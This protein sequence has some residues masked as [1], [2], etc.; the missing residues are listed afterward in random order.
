MS[1]IPGLYFVI[2]GDDLARFVRPDPDNGLHTIETMDFA[3]IHQRNG[4]TRS[5]E[6]DEPP[7][8]RFA[9]LLATLIDEDFAVDLFSHLVLVAPP[10]LLHTLTAT[11]DPSTRAS[12]YGSLAKNLVTVPDLELWPHFLTWL[13]PRQT[14]WAP[15]LPL[16][17]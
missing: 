17:D 13:Q 16:E 10:G 14:A 9:H 6:P 1:G 12:L 11:L 15:A 7:H 5:P 3:A 2:A 4:P 8:P